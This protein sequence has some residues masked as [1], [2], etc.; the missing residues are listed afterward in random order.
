[1]NP[2]QVENLLA[3]VRAWFHNS[4]E[5][6]PEDIREFIE[7]AI[8]NGDHS[9]GVEAAVAWAKGFMWTPEVVARD[10]Q[11]LLE[12]GQNF[13]QMVKLR[14]AE[15]APER[16]SAER[17][18]GLHPDNPEIPLMLRIAEGMTVPLPTDFIP[19]GKDTTGKL[20]KAYLDAAPAVDRMLAELHE[21]GLGFILPTAVAQG[22]E[23]CHFATASWTQKKDK[24]CGRGLS[25]MTHCRGM[26]LNTE[27]TKQAA[28]DIWGAIKHPTINEIVE[29]VWT[30]W[31]K[32][33]KG[34]KEVVWEDLVIW[35]MDLRGAYTLLSI[36]PDCAALFALELRDGLTFIPCCG[37]F[38]W[39]AIPFIFQTVTRAV[40]WEI[41]KVVRGLIDMY[42]DDIF[43][44][45]L[46]WDLKHDLRVAR[47]ACTSLL[48]PKAVADPKTDHG[49]HL[50]ILGWHLDLA[51]GFL[52]IARKNLL[53]AFLAFCSVDVSSPV[54]IKVMQK[55]ASLSSRYS[56]VCPA[57][58]PFTA[59]LNRMIAGFTGRHVQ[60]VISPEAT[61][62]IVMWRAMLY[63]MAGHEARYARPLASFRL[64]AASWGIQTDASL[65]GAG[66]ICFQ[67][68]ADGSRIVRGGFAV[69]LGPM[70]FGCDSSFQNVSEF[71]GIVM[72]LVALALIGVRDV[73]LEVEGDSRAALA[74]AQ[75][76]C[77]RSSSATRAS[78]VFTLVCLAFGFSIAEASHISGEDNWQADIL[79]RLVESE[80]VEEALVRIGYPGVPV[81]RVSDNVHANTLLSCCVPDREG[82]TMGEVEFTPFWGRIRESLK[83]LEGSKKLYGWILE[84]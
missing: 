2:R 39:T 82:K 64:K 19:N 30:F 7:E 44:V 20:S 38:G 26:S 50:D 51:A 74:W 56:L 10:A 48:G 27:E 67:R 6:A 75:S 77:F 43:G 40:K 58:A 32:C 33:Q 63:L 52:S 80:S 37:V 61:L 55:L 12:A 28:E 60:I 66:G 13:G 78:M 25:D 16:L 71:V 21:Q 45:T 68:G 8:K 1:M 22:V 34:V 65:S 11:L 23:N 14:L 18:M 35:K 76:N 53:T 73:A 17:V 79:S 4:E 36:H 41:R 47:G 29:L 70:E 57:M 31:D 24:A 81:I 69:D 54:H 72:G 5:Y 49:H 83:M 62:S 42:V 15:L 59:A 9:Y 3:G 46:A 84:N